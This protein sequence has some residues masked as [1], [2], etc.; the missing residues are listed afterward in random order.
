MRVP[1]RKN[2]STCIPKW[3]TK[4]DCC[5]RDARELVTELE[6]VWDQI[7]NNSASSSNSSP[8]RGIPQYSQPRQF[9]RPKSGQDGPMRVLSPMSQD[10]EA[11]H[12]S[13]RRINQEI[14]AEEFDEDEYTTPEQARKGTKQWRKQVEATLVKMT[15]EMAA[16]REQIATGR[17]W[18]GRQRRTIGAWIG[19]FVWTTIRHFFID[20]IVLGIILFWMRRRKD[21]RIEDLVREGLR[22]M[23]EYARRFLPAR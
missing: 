18:R 11:E 1:L 19:W 9:T 14:G 6:F 8:A 5:Y 12:R 20:V 21:G 4:T 17:E 22:V 13:E 10:D 23:R 3:D 7:K 16:L 15:A 2:S